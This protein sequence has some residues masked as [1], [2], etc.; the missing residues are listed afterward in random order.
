MSSGWRDVIAGWGAAAALVALIARALAQRDAV[1]T[2]VVVT[3]LNAWWATALGVAA[4]GFAIWPWVGHGVPAFAHDWKWPLL[5]AQLDAWPSILRSL[6]LPW[7]A[8]AP[9]VQEVAQYPIVLFAWIAGKVLSPAWSL[10]LMLAL[11]FVICATGAARCGRAFG[12]E[13]SWQALLAFLYPLAPAA[14]N[15]LSAGHLPWLVGYALVPWMI[16]LAVQRAPSWSRAGRLGVLWGFAAAQVQFLLIA[17]VALL[18][19]G[20]RTWRWDIAL[21]AAIACGMQAPM[22]AAL[23]CGHPATAFA[24]AHANIDWQLAQ[25]SRATIALAGAADPAG[26]FQSFEP[27]AELLLAPLIALAFFGAFVTARA[28]PLA[29]LWIGSALWVAG[30]RGPL[31][32]MFSNAFSHVLA[33]S[34]F[35]EFS[36][37]AVLVML[38]ILVLAAFGARALGGKRIA[39]GLAVFAV[40][41]VPAAW[42]GLTASAARLDAPV[43][44]E[45]SFIVPAIANLPGNGAV[46]WMPSVQPMRMAQTRGGADSLA[47]PIGD[48]PP[49]VEYRP[50]VPLIVATRALANGDRAACGLL[51][52]LGIQ[53]VVMRANTETV[54]SLR[55]AASAAQEAVTRAQYAAQRVPAPV[56]SGLKSLAVLG[57]VYAYSVPCYRGTLTWAQ[58][59]VVRGDWTTLHALARG[60]ASDEITLPPAPPPGVVATAPPRSTYQTDDITRDWVPLSQADAYA[61]RFAGAF[62]DVAI[63][64]RPDAPLDG[65]AM[66]ASGGNGP[67]AWMSA[68]K[69]R[70]LL[71]RGPV[72]VWQ[73]GQTGGV[74][75]RDATLDTLATASGHRAISYALFKRN[76]S[77]QYSGPAP[78]QGSLVVL[79]QHSSGGWQALVD[80]NALASYPADGFAQGWIVD[81]PGTLTVRYAAPP[82]SLLWGIVA[83]AIAAA[84]AMA[85]ARPKPETTA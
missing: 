61:D 42:P 49:F 68:A 65:A 18:A 73:V 48:H 66:L 81:R 39:A 83:A 21:A 6:W 67:Y 71:R 5:S 62:D 43:R 26:Y 70:G 13:R 30:M 44:V 72:A 1:K 7:G 64:A 51:A 77:L 27:S 29:I 82:I 4:C 11:L 9:A 63:T 78:P 23:L 3:M 69:L 22:I 46:L 34:A 59:S 50:S 55:G 24:P 41:C 8:G 56:R 54:P 60:G 2:P 57:E 33:L 12:L 20:R 79:H 80:G 52:N 28:V 25:S 84:I 17:P 36:H 74:D 47:F 14:T 15:R 16:A 32:P 19:A 45:Y 85:F 58:A 10:Y 31:A 53:A 38:P 37:V 76:A 75:T 40:A 35:R